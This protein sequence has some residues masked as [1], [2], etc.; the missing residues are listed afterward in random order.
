GKLT[1]LGSVSPGLS[2]GTLSILGSFDFGTGSSYQYEVGDLLSISGSL[3][4]DGPW[5]VNASGVPMGTY[6]IAT[7]LGGIAPSV[8]SQGSVVGAS[9]G[10]EIQNND[11]LLVIPEPSVATLVGMA[12]SGMLFLRRKV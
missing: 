11:L 6:T 7:A 12:A 9:G 4:N 8:A 5:T 3:T 2:P 10:L 1:L